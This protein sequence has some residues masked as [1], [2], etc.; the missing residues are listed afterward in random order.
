MSIIESRWRERQSRYED[1]IYFATD[2]FIR[3]CGTP[4]EGYRADARAAIATLLHATRDGWTH[5]DDVCFA[6]VG[7]FQFFGGST[8]WE[9]QALSPSSIAPQ[10]IFFGYSTLRTASRLRRFHAA[11]LP[12][13]PFRTSILSGPH[14]GFRS[15]HPRA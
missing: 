8:S 3:L 7:D 12:F 4:R 11:V 15:M 6:G 5:L 2:D 10:G 1:G 9:E 13:M 14:G